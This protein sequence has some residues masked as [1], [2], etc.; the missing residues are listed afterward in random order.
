CTIEHANL[1]N[2]P[3]YT[4][5]SYVWGSF[6]D[7]MPVLIGDGKFLM[8]TRTLMEVLFQFSGANT[9][10]DVGN[11]TRLLWTDQ[12]CISQYDAEERGKRVALM[13]RIYTQ[14]E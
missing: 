5:I 3:T 8:V 14:A 1:D 2:N 12:L 9:P 10:T 7:I 11:T 13:R 4:A 6:D